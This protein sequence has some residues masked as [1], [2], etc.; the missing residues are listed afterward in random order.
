M[1][2]RLV[3]V[4]SERTIRCCY[5]S[6]SSADEIIIDL[7]SSLQFLSITPSVCPD[8]DTPAET[9]E[10]KLVKQFDHNVVEREN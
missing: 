7:L 5:S 1:P 9:S 3:G 8:K 10:S 6:H 4:V 2:G